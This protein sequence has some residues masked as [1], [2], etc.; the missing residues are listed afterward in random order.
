MLKKII[1]A[2]V[3]TLVLGLSCWKLFFSSPSIKEDLNNLNQAMT[4]YH[5]EANMEIGE[6]EEV[7][8]FYVVVDFKDEEK[9]LEL[10]NFDE[11][12]DRITVAEYNYLKKI[13]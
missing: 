6:G 1:I 9:F 4:S 8:K 7:R 11:T 12:S 3:V 13:A 2:V 5:M 10:L